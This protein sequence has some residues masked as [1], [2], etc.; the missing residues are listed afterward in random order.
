MD[1][2]FINWLVPEVNEVGYKWE[3]LSLSCLPNAN[4]DSLVLKGT[5]EK[6]KDSH[7]L[8]VMFTKWNNANIFIKIRIFKEKKYIFY[9]KKFEFRELLQQ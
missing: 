1:D 9:R 5:R 4:F 2:N 8:T 6:P 3:Y 7:R